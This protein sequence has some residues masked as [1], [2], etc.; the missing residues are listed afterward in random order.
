MPHQVP[1]RVYHHPGETVRDRERDQIQRCDPA[2]MQRD[3]QGGVLR[4]AQDGVQERAEA[5]H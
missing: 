3:L 1:G 4:H 2:Q 5:G